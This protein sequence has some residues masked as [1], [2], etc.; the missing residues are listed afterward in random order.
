MANTTTLLNGSS[1]SCSGHARYIN[2]YGLQPM[3]MH[4]HLWD[5]THLSSCLSASLGLRGLVILNL[6][7]FPDPPEYTILGLEIPNVI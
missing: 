3:Q 7:S 2:Y 1:Q 5:T 6:L 4:I